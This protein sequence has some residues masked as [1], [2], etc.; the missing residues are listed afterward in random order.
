MKFLNLKR[1]RTEN[2]AKIPLKIALTILNKIYSIYI[3]FIYYFIYYFY[4][5]I[6]KERRDLCLFDSTVIVGFL[7]VVGTLIGSFGGIMAANKLTNY[8]IA[9]LEK[10]VDKHNT[11]IERTYIVERDMKTVFNYVD[12]FKKDIKNLKEEVQEIRE[13]EIKL[14]NDRN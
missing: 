8:R 6:T 11:I 13:E 1:I 14:S 4:I 2:T 10:K 3:I 12:E 5:H 9:E 7:S